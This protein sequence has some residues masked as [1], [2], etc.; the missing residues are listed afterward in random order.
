MLR[1]HGSVTRGSETE[2]TENNSLQGE[3]G[4]SVSRERSLWSLNVCVI[5]LIELV[6][7]CFHFGA[8]TPSNLNLEYT[9]K[10]SNLNHDM[11]LLKALQ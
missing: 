9:F 8:I 1:L 7:F 2:V 10:N 5:S 6:T 11:A 3:G 4:M